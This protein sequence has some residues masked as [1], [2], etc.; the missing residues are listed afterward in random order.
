MIPVAGHIA[1]RSCWVHGRF[2]IVLKVPRL[3]L[4]CVQA[5][6]HRDCR[7]RGCQDHHELLRGEC[8][9][10]NTWLDSNHPGIE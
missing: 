8:E 2:G 1:V 6:L 4:A 10:E 3:I 7:F 5:R 9:D